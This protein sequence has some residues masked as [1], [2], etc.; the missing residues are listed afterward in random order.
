MIAN[1]N[2]LCCL[3]GS[4]YFPDFT[5]K[6]LLLEQMGVSFANE[7]RMLY[8]LKN[9]GVFNQIKGLII[10][11]PEFLDTAGAEFSYDELIQSIIGDVDYP[12]ITGFDCS[13]THPMHSLAQD[14]LVEFNT[15]KIGALT[16]LE[17][18]VD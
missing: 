12:V 4:K 3:A 5:D 9:A 15:D 13:H 6:I 17:S 2:T 18:A 14:L 7:E 8:Q 16:L 1:I 11:K 10:G